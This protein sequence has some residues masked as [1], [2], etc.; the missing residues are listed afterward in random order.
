[1][2]RVAVVL[3]GVALIVSLGFNVFMANYIGK[4]R[5]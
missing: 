1:M 3:L 2:R 4:Q 5:S